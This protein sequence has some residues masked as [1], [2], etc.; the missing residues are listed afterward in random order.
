MAKI[1]LKTRSQ[2]KNFIKRWNKF[3]KKLDTCEQHGTTKY[4]TGSNDINVKVHT[5]KKHRVK[6]IGDCVYLCVAHNNT[7]PNCQRHW[8]FYS[9]IKKLAYLAYPPKNII[10][11]QRCY[12]HSGD[13]YWETIRD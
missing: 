12:S 3:Y 4:Y 13:I 6:I 11:K 5:Y 8:D 7:N 10:M 9:P 2:T 1:R